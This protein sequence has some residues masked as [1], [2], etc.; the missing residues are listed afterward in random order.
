MPSVYSDRVDCTINY[1]SFLQL[2]VPPQ[3][4][5]SARTRILIK[6]LLVVHSSYHTRIIYIL[7]YT[8]Y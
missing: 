2:N 6:G 1:N 7:K 5:Q 4:P 3:L 8:Q